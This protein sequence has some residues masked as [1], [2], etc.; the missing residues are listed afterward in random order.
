MG[1]SI[2][3]GS[4]LIN[5]GFKILAVMLILTGCTTPP[6][7]LEA[8]S[9]S[10]PKVEAPIYRIPAYRRTFKHRVVSYSNEHVKRAHDA[11]V[12][13]MSYTTVEKDGKTILSNVVGRGSGV[14]HIDYKKK[15]VWVWTVHHVVDN[16]DK[17]AV[18]FKESA[19]STTGHFYSAQV[20]AVSPVLDLALLKVNAKTD[21]QI[22]DFTSIDFYTGELPEI[23][24]PIFH[25][26]NFNSRTMSGIENFTSGHISRYLDGE[27]VAPRIET[28]V[29]TYYGSSGGGLFFPKDGKCLGL[30]STFAKSGLGMYVPY[31]EI[32]AWAKAAG[33]P[34]AVD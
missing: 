29:K 27:S 13:V 5:Y 12:Q 33:H 3:K 30:A 31:Y 4:L 20:V 1:F 9:I 18:L 11:S 34:G 25:F 2:R 6:K 19:F 14:I 22:S 26:G 24:A 23:G 28:T 7:K 21:D 32:R 16:Y 8:P 10:I 17:L 15:E